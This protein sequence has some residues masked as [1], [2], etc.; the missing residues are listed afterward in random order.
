MNDIPPQS[1]EIE[2][3]VLGAMLIDPEAIVVALDL[4]DE[5]V[6]YRPV[7]QSI[8]KVIRDLYSQNT[9]IDQLIVAE[10]LQKRGHLDAVGGE[11]AIAALMAECF[12]SAN[13]T[14][15]C[16][17]LIEKAKVRNII[18]FAATIKNMCQDETNT[19]DDIIAEAELQLSTIS[20]S[21]SANESL[22][23]IKDIIIDTYSRMIKINESDSRLVGVDTGFPRLNEYT[24]GFQ[25]GDL[26][27]VAGKTGHGKTSFAMN[28]VGNV[29]RHGHSVGVFSLEMSQNEVAER[30][31][32]SE[33]RFD[34][35]KIYR[36]RLTAIDWKQLNDG[37]QRLYNQNIIICDTGGISI[38]ELILQA[39][40]MKRDHDIK[41]LVVD[42]LQLVSAPAESRQMEVS[43]VG[44]LLKALA[45]N[46]NI[47][48]M[49]LSQ[50]SRKIDERRGE[51]MLSDLRE[52]GSIE[53]DSNIVLMLYNPHEFGETK[54]YGYG[55]DNK[56]I[57][58]LIVGK[59]RSGKTG[60][61][62]LRWTPE[63]TNFGTLSLYG[64]G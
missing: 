8:F 43:K 20:E 16:K 9:P 53:Q 17:M 2:R 64:V 61:I 14:T 47:P 24:G 3:A 18:T 42:Y 21:R 39:K 57:R 27:V 37:C 62:L 56:Y 22:C 15:H 54:D 31:L 55:D 52:S 12:S 11:A 26:I 28:C 7:Y 30:L 10:E 36:D 58:E 45:K 32:Q 29:A 46:L 5:T 19:P 59:N 49:A 48:L 63:H 51:P 23:T 50:F 35:T 13:I 44:R 34:I 60:K 33:A 6:F 4:I 1:R 38:S 40:R 41:L 25:C